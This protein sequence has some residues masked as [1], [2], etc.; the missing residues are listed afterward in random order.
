M[1]TGR[2]PNANME[3]YMEKNASLVY[4]IFIL[5]LIF[6]FPVLCFGFEG[7]G[8]NYEESVGYLE[9]EEFMQINGLLHGIVFDDKGYMFV[10][11][12]GKEILKISPEGSVSLFS[13]IKEADG[14]FVEGPGQTFLYDMEFDTHGHLIAAVEDRI[15]KFSKDG[16]YTTLVEKKFPGFWGTCGIAL[17]QK[18]NVFF[19]YDNKIMKLTPEGTQE[20]FFDGGQSTPVLK[21]IVGIE[22]TPDYRHLFA[23]DGKHLSGQVVKIPIRSDGNSGPIELIYQ[24]KEFSMEYIA[25]DKDFNPIIKGP[26]SESFV[27]VDKNGKVDLLGHTDF[28]LGIQT[29]TRGGQGFDQNAIYGTEMFNGAIYKIVLP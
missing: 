6:Y 20:L 16:K 18:N 27:R 24:K 21:A 14:F 28:G 17:D 15:L 22:F 1:S 9:I 7:R 5:F 12:N 29:I 13:E 8:I 26:W 25:F 2:L 10:G 19:A 4:L 3:I 23:C 11:R